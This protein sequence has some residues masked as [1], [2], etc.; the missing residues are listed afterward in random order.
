MGVVV[1]FCGHHFHRCA[2]D[3][4]GCCYCR[5]GL[6]A[7]DVCGGAEA[8]LPTDCPGYRMEDELVHAVIAREVDYTRARGWCRI[9]LRLAWV[10]PFV[11][12][13][14]EKGEN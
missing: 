2:P 7:C 8:S 12:A 9:P 11:F 5:G 14:F 1:H 6:L 3:C 4:R 10:R 13:L